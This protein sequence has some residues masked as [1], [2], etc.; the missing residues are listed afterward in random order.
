[1]TTLRRPFAVLAATAAGG[2]LAACTTTVP[3]EG[4]AP[5]ESSS[6]AAA[7]EESA[8]EETSQE[9]SGERVVTTDQGDITVPAD[10]ERIVVLNANL[11]GYLYALDVPVLATLPETPGPG[12]GDYPEAYAE[13]AADDG[14]VILPWGEDGFDYEAILTQDPDLIIAGG[15]GFAAFQAGESVDRLAEIAP[16]VLVSTELLT[17]QEQLSFIAGDVLDEGE[18]EQELLAA[19]DARV[20][21]VSEAITLP[22]TPVAYLVLTADGTPYSLPEDSALPQTLAEVGFEPAPVVADNPDFEAYGTGDSFELSTEQVS[23]VFTA[24]T[25]FAFGFVDEGADP[26]TLATDP[27]YAGLPAFQSDQVYT[28]PYWAYRAD[29]LRTMDLLDVIEQRFS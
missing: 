4:S 28:L 20:A 18:K 21:E 23:Q 26:A 29:Y 22:P 12:G 2:L 6:E 8:T 14:T 9:T 7:G 5:G 25:I 10:A 11:A 16:T 13:D 1:M 17:W 15:Q 3:D 27:V 24:P 19:Y